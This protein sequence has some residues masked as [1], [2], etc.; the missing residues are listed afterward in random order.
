MI[1]SIRLFEEP[2]ARHDLGEHFGGGPALGLLDRG[3]VFAFV[4]LHAGEV[5]GLDAAALREAGLT[6]GDVKRRLGIG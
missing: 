3:Q 1:E 2:G 4:R 5:A 6:P